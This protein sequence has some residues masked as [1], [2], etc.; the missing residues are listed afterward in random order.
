[1]PEGNPAA[2]VGAM[3]ELAE[4]AQ[5]GPLLRDWR[6]RRRMSQLDLALGAGVSARHVSFIETGRSRPSAEMVVQL[7]EHLDVPLRDRNSLLLAAG[8][9]PAYGQRDLADPEMGPVREAIDRLLRGHEPFP[10]VVVDRHWGLV[11]GNRTVPLLVEGAAEHLLEPPANV[12]RLALHPEGMAPRI[13]NLGEWRAH[14]LD[15]LGRQAVSSGD[16]ALFA[17]HEEL[18]GYPG[19]GGAHSVDLEAGEIA[20]PLRIR[21][22]DGELAFISTATTFGTAVDVTVSELSIES[23]F[24]ADDVTARALQAHKLSD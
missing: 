14:L 3:S 16:P 24:P 17:L 19:G 22:G 15:R 21:A 13:A 8:Y 18:A 1:M 23:F 4:R 6:E 2:T 12:L 7:A 10:A 11:A 20:V 9:A 5:I